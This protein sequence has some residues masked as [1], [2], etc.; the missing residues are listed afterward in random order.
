MFSPQSINMPLL[1]SNFQTGSKRC[2]DFIQSVIAEA[3]GIADALAG[4]ILT[5]LLPTNFNGNDALNLYTQARQNGNVSASGNSGVTILPNGDRQTTYGTTVGRVTQWNNEFYDL[6]AAN[7]GF[8]TIHESLHHIRGFSDQALAE[9]ARRTIGR[10]GST[11]TE[12]SEASAYF[13][14]ILREYCND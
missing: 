4:Y 11:P 3:S 1:R 9:A 12:M 5:P 13:N 2:N 6:S 10:D 14:A 8:H 7:R